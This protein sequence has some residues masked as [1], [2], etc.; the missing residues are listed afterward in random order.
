MRMDV[1]IQA[2]CKVERAVAQEWHHGDRQVRR[3]P[4]GK[5]GMG[6]REQG[7]LGHLRQEVR[8]FPEE[9]SWQR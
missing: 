2:G 9:S 6:R 5:I 1:A 7:E 4:E 8:T 3:F